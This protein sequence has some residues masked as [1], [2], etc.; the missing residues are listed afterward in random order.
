MSCRA[1][2]SVPSLLTAIKERREPPFSPG[3]PRHAA[4]GKDIRREDGVRVIRDAP[5]VPAVEIRGIEGCDRSAGPWVDPSVTGGE[6]GD[7][8]GRCIIVEVKERPHP[9]R[10]GGVTGIVGDTDSGAAIGVH[11]P[12][13]EPFFARPSAGKEDLSAIE[14]NCRVAG[15]EE[16]IGQRSFGPIR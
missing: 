14:G 4:I 5:R 7:A 2:R 10:S 8:F 12:D 13:L 3:V 6:V 15:S 16:A 1:M 11:P 9:Q